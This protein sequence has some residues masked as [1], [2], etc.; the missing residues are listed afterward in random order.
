[1][2]DTN[3]TVNVDTKEAL[4]ALKD[5]QGVFN[6]LISALALKQLAD[7]SDG[8]TNI[9]NRLRA[10]APD[11]A[12]ANKQFDA[13]VGI[14]MSSRAPLKD[15]AETFSKLQ[16]ATR[17]L[18]LSQQQ[19]GRV[20]ET[21]TK[22]LAI[23]GTSSIEASSAMYQFNQAMALGTFQGNDLHSLVQTMPAVMLGFADSIGKPIGSLKDLGANGEITSAMMVKYLMSISEQTDK[24]FSNM[25][26]TFKQAFTEV[27]NSI[28]LVFNNFEQNTSAG[29]NL[30]NSIEYI[31]FT[32]YKLGATVDQWSDTVLSIAK[33]TAIILSFTLVGKVISV[34]IGLIVEL[35]T[36]IYGLGKFVFDATKY[37]WSLSEGMAGLGI[38]LSWL[39]GTAQVFYTVFKP[40]IDLFIDGYD[41]ISKFFDGMK[42]AGDSTSKSGQELAK[43]REEMKKNAGQLDETVN[44][45]KVAEE[46]KKKLAYALSLVSL[47]SRQQTDDLKVNLD[48]TLEKLKFDAEEIGAYK[49]KTS[50]VFEFTNKSKDQIE[51]ETALRDLQFERAD[52]IRK[53]TQ[54][55]AKLQAELKNPSLL[56]EDA[57][58]QKTKEIQGRIA[59]IGQQIVKERELYDNQ[60]KAL[61]AYIIQ[62]QTA[63]LLEAD[64]VKQTEIITKAIEDQIAR[65]EKLASITR[66]LNDQKITLGFETGQIGKG[67]F[68]K[69]LDNITE[70]ARKAAL[71][72]SRSFSEMFSGEDGLTLEKA[73][74]LDAGLEK[75]R[76]KF[77]G[78]AEQQTENA[79]TARTWEAGWKEAFANYAENAQNAAEEA[80]SYFSTFTK[81]FEDLIVNFV[82]TGKLNFR[83]FALSI[84]AE[85][86]KIQ[87]AKMAVNLFGS[88]PGGGLL[89]G[90][91]GGFFGGGGTP[92]GSGASI[93]AGMSAATLGLFGLASGG[94]VTSPTRALVG[95]SG[96]EAVIPLSKL[97]DIT[98]SNKQG[99]MA[100]T[101]NI[102]ATDAQSFRTMI[103]RDPQFI[104]NVTEA[105]R[106]SQPTRRLA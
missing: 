32:I 47:A 40:I 9:N 71:E 15:V 100:I 10:L 72:A 61:P 59:I 49:D 46:Q 88:S 16:I 24:T 45:D 77:A 95:E 36:G 91:F 14:A 42:T 50:A 51:V 79:K 80:R 43:F 104:Y 54:E 78:I 26:P 35:G 66:S 81:G 4:S 27:G 52:A 8:L 38:R 23:N 18:G 74:E 106:R 82:K 53:L 11:M 29:K 3:L 30:A 105:G 22:Q 67:T 6:T 48:R 89:G 62:L 44:K 55:Q 5:L 103:A 73:Q 33:W 41:A 13:I 12:T 85:F 92:A 97:A 87:A 56:S 101:Y 93:P 68:Q 2:A 21:L 60:A 17:D 84:I 99:S 63:K 39:S 64:R 34:A 102:N 28:S 31:A 94:I 75:I 1:M 19:V 20:T 90:I 7:F 25:A 86:A 69:Q 83:D 58:G 96:S 70:N 37:I 98:G 65:S 57:G 76:L